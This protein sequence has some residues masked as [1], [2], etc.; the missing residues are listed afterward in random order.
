MVCDSIG[1]QDNIFLWTDSTIVLHW[2]SASPSSWQTFVGNRVAEIQE[3]TAHCSWHHVPGT[4]NPAD[5]ISRG[6]DIGDLIDSSLWW[7]GPPWLAEANQ[8]WPEAPESFDNIKE[9]HLEARK[10]LVLSIANSSETDLIEN[11]SS[12]TRLLR[13]AALCRRFFAK[14][15]YCRQVRK[16]LLHPTEPPLPGPI[17]VDE[18][19]KTLLAIVRRVQEQTFG[20]EFAALR[21]EKPL[22]SSSPLRYLAPKLCGDLIRV[23]GRLSYASIS[24]EAK[25]PLVLPRNHYLSRLIAET[26]HRDQ[27]HCGPQF[28]LATLRQR[29]WPLGGRN[30]VRSVV[31]GC[32]TCVKAR[33]RSLSQQMGQLPAL[34]VT[35][36]YAFENVGIDFAG[37][38]YLKRP[39]P[40]SAPVK[41]YVA[42]FICMATKA[43]HLEL[44]SDL[45]SASFIACLRRFEGRRGRPANIFCDNA[46]NF[47]GA[48]RELRNLFRSTEHRHAVVN[49][50]ADQLVRFNFIP[51]RSPSFGGLWE[52]C[53]KIMKHQLRRIIGNAFRNAVEA[54][55][56]S[57]PITP[58]TSDPNDM[59]VL[60]PGH[61]I[62]G[63]PLNALPERDV[64]NAPE[65]LLLR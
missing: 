62:T 40:R 31:H 25:N 33:P 37:P 29:F 39:S 56:N 10:G 57:R 4:E 2:L 65:G 63:R 45:T 47:V 43:V 17:T 44:V 54:C 15:R 12:F 50:T 26:M 3:L 28:L 16:S 64:T 55:L 59:R 38:F 53:V 14:I 21:S 34:R 5:L 11:F 61:F 20:Q 1:L 52:S 9:R 30:L 41:S 46:T 19:N 51:P 18:L 6:L 36:S 35:Q 22:P 42:V 60:T 23:G 8:P 24:S 58:L 7:N 32:V 49:E 13:I 48:D 27:L